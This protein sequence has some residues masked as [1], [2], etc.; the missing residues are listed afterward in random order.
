MPNSRDAGTPVPLKSLSPARRRL[1]LNMKEIRF[2]RIEGLRVRDGEPVLDP[3]PRTLRD[4]KLGRAPGDAARS[5]GDDFTLKAE[6]VDLLDVLER[7]QTFTVELIE[8]LHGLPHRMV[9]AT[10]GRA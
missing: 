7:E 9:I 4:I 8:I 1:V 6:V 2:G 5:E 3:P 10:E